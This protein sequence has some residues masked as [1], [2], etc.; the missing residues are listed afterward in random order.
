MKNTNIII[1]ANPSITDDQ[2]FGFYVR[3]HICEE[4]YGK[5]L[6]CRPLRHSSLIVG[7][8]EDDKLIGITRAMFDGLSASIMEF[9][10]D[11]EYQGNKIAYRNGSL[12]GNDVKGIGLK[13]GKV[14]LDELDR[15]GASFISY[16]VLRN[17]EEPF[18]QLLGFEP[19]RDAITYIIDKRPYLG[20][21]KY[22]TRRN[23]EL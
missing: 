21:K 7:A 20:D 11:L 22:I 16:R 3:N 13:M 14:L 12:I 1:M 4:G 19:H 18:F 17:Y 2:L 9:S 5:E 15:M 8:F 10:L 23:S 6:G